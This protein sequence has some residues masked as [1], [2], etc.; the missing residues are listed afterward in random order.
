MLK[1]ADLTY[2]SDGTISVVGLDQD[3]VEA[4]NQLDQAS[5]L[6]D[7]ITASA[8]IEKLSVAGPCKSGIYAGK[9]SCLGSNGKVLMS[10][11]LIYMAPGEN[12]VPGTTLS[13]Q[14][15]TIPDNVRY[16]ANRCTGSASPV[17]FDIDGKRLESSANAAYKC[18][19]SYGTGAGEGSCYS[20]VTSDPSVTG[21]YAVTMFIYSNNLSN[22]TYSNVPITDV[23]NV[24]AAMPALV[25][26]SPV[27]AT[28]AIYANQ[29][30]KQ[31]QEAITQATGKIVDNVGKFFVSR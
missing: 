6:G 1:V 18:L 30:N 29:V 10:K 26:L 22:V 17:Y 14:T 20:G 31:I 27:V 24:F 9:V 19:I 11:F 23:Q 28:T 4:F 21:Q 13:S 2:N 25:S 12:P 15:L 7:Y 16:Y 5:N 8:N 3:L